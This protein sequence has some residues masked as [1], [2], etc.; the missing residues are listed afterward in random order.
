MATAIE[1]MTGAAER[2]GQRADPQTFNAALVLG[3]HGGSCRLV[4]F[5][6]GLLFCFCLC[7]CFS[8][9][10]LRVRLCLLLRF[11]LGVFLIGLLGFRGR[12]RFTGGGLSSLGTGI[13]CHHSLRN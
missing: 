11:D 13:L 7:S 3:C 1:L 4:L 5:V 2:R 8:S 12:C 6:C 10:L 9:V